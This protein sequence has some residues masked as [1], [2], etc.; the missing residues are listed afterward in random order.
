LAGERQCW[1]RFDRQTLVGADLAIAPTT[2]VAAELCR[3]SPRTPVAVVSNGVDI[4]ALRTMPARGRDIAFLG[5][6]SYAPNI[7]AVAWFADRIW[8]QL[9]T[10]H[11]STEVRV[12]G[13]EPSQLARSL[14]GAGIRI[15]GAVDDVTDACEGVRI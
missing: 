10:A 1:R 5:W 11:A 9:R 12:I 15:V 7:D 8:P 13:R 3:I 6:M 4:R 2:D 14:G